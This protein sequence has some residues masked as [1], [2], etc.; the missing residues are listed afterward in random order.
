MS[1][2]I[3]IANIPIASIKID[4]K[5]CAERLRLFIK[6]NFTSVN[7]AAK[8]L[9]TT[10][11]TLRSS[12]LSGRSILGPELLIRLYFLGCDLKWLLT[13]EEEFYLIGMKGL[14][15]KI[16]TLIRKLNKEYGW[17]GEEMPMATFDDDDKLNWRK[18]KADFLQARWYFSNSLAPRDL[19]ELCQLTDTDVN[20]FLGGESA[21]LKRTKAG[22]NI[23]NEELELIK[24]LRTIPEVGKAI[25]QLLAGKIQV[26]K[27]NKELD[28]VLQKNLIKSKY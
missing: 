27:L 7:A 5:E 23:S 2:K 26:S 12:Y 1:R 10:G 14:K 20:E 21:L 22:I 16:D 28:K 11:N 13:G 6:R 17:N 4:K 3:S 9:G 15:E 24:T 19:V 8:V 25:H 18:T